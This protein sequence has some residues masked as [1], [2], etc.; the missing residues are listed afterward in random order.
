[1]LIQQAKG[2]YSFSHLTFQE[3]FAAE[4]IVENREP[5]FL[6]NFVEE[7]LI[8]RHWREVF[9][10]IT[11]RLS[12]ADEF[13]KLMF[14]CTNDLVKDNKE[15]QK[16][17]AW[18]D[19]MTTAADIKSSAWRAYYLTIDLD[20]DLYISRDIQI[21]R[22]S[23]GKLATE[24]RNFNVE[25]KKLT[26]PQP[27]A[28]LIS[29]LAAIH[30]LAIDCANEY[31][32]LEYTSLHNSSEFTRKRLQVSEN[33]EIDI[34]EKL[35]VA[36][37]KA[38]EINLSDLTQEL[39]YLQSIYPCNDDSSQEWQKWA[40]KLRQ[41]MLQHLDVGYKVSFSSEDVKA[42]EN[43]IYANSLLLE[44]IS[45]ESYSSRELREEIID[46]LLLPTDKILPHLL[47]I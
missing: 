13:L 33:P 22:S 44:C 25:Q 37:E 10:L 3:F 47:S 11:E 7:N 27:K 1:L 34:H 19:R 41:V 4:Y 16:M 45:G 40:E 35:S 29:R 24:M 39:I 17:L 8:K 28:L 15:L 12:N 14:K 26:P 30:A 42:L 20:V 21:D 23:F 43:Y 38:K 6:N 32:T 31:A 46:N 36:I 2:I 18:L 9:I 5:K